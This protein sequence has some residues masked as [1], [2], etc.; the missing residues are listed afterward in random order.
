MKFFDALL[1]PD[2]EED[3]AR[4]KITHAANLL[5]VGE[6][7]LLQLAFADWHG[8]EMSD[9]EERYF[10]RSF[11]LGNEVP[12]YLRHY[13]RTIVAQ[14]D[15][16]RLNIDAPAYH[17]FDND[18]SRRHV[19]DGWNRFLVVATVIVGVVGGGIVMA[20]YTVKATGRCTETL[21]P[22]FTEAELGNDASR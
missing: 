7:Q 1:H 3:P 8:R 22:C 17:R 11:A 6:F 18:F 13:A 10:F 12:P 5:Q 20:S 14:A 16:G 21:P 19:A 15:D 9:E 4:A 2:R